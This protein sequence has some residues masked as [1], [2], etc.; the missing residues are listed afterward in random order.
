MPT[1]PQL[2]QPRL[3]AHVSV[4]F[5]HIVEAARRIGPYIHRTPILTSAYFNDLFS[6]ELFF[7]CE[8]LQRIGA[9]KARGA[10]NAVMQLDAETAR[11]G[12]ITHSSGNHAQ[13]LAYAATLRSIP[14]TIVMPRTAPLIKKQ[15]VMGYGAMVVE[16]EPTLEDRE[17]T[18]QAIAQQTGAH[19]VPPYNDERVIAGQGTAAMELLEDVA[20]LD[21]IMAPVG[22]GGLMSG[23]AIAAR[24]MVPNI[25]IIG[26]EPAEAADARI[27]LETG[28]LQGPPQTMTIADGLRTALG[29]ITFGILQETHVR[30]VTASEDSIRE[31]LFRVMERMKQ[32]V[33]PSA[34]VTIGALMEQPDLVRG[35]RVGVIIC[36]GNL[37]I[38]TLNR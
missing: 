32:V 3:R 25:D 9:F 13:A 17:R 10:C 31:G 36:G 28:V 6:A 27:S 35:K 15:A 34:T 11:H 22:G 14:C 23:T 12:V 2:F 20:N 21:V 24:A 16:C 37:D 38:R 29:D 26:A 33:E 7:K 18:M 4:T 5:H 1:V 19:I 30:I 8:H